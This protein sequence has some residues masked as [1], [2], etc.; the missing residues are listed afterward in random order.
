VFISADIISV[1]ICAKKELL[2]EGG[3]EIQQLKE[4]VIQFTAKFQNI[5]F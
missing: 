3:S 2:G 4:E 5:G 1:I